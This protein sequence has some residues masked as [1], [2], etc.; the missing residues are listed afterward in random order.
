MLDNGSALCKVVERGL[1]TAS[2]FATVAEQETNLI[3]L[4]PR[5]EHILLSRLMMKAI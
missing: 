1:I 4:F 2:G 5:A 3:L